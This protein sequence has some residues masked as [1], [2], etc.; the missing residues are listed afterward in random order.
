M[1]KDTNATKI[2]LRGMAPLLQVFDM[3]ASLRFYRDMLGFVVVEFSGAADDVDWV[4]LSFND[5]SL[6]LNTTYEKHI[7]PSNR[8]PNG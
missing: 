6:M 8:K 5:I 4:L 3:P 2:C 1:N 7:R